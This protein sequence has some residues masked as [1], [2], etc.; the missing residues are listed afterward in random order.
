MLSY[1]IMLY[2]LKKDYKYKFLIFICVF[3]Y[4]GDNV[5]PLSSL[6]LYNIWFNSR[7]CNNRPTG[8][9]FSNST[10]GVLIAHGIWFN[11]HQDHI[12]RLSSLV[13]GLWVI[14]EIS[15]SVQW[16]KCVSTSFSLHFTDLKMSNLS[17]YSLLLIFILCVYA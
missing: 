11:A 5:V 2:Y 14:S 15:S 17:H 3:L 4:S 16:I 6:F 7:W 10:H 8:F 12:I 1:N 13:Q 9:S